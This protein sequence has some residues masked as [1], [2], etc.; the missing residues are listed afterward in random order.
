MRQHRQFYQTLD[1]TDAQSYWAGYL[2]PQA[3]PFALN[4]EQ[5]WLANAN[6]H[7]A[8][9]HNGW[10]MPGFYKHLRM[11]RAAD[12]LSQDRTFTAADMR[13]MQLDQR[14]ERALQWK[15]LLADTAERTGRNGLA[16]ELR[17]WDGMM[18]AESDLAGLFARWWQ[19]LPQHLFETSELEDWRFGRTLLDDWMSLPPQDIEIAAIEL[20]QAAERAFEDALKLGL[21]PLGSI[22]HLTIRHP[23]ASAGIL[24][25][26]LNLSRG[27]IPIG[28]GPGSL[29]VTYHRWNAEQARL[30]AAAGPSMRFVMDWANP[31]AFTLNTTM[32]QSGHPL[33]P[34]FD[35]FLQ[36]FLTGEPWT[37]PFSS[38]RVQNQSISTLWLV[39]ESP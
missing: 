39:P 15:G 2:E 33:S 34:H 27:P 7:A 38:E 3:R 14:S 30:S 31:D 19:F 24:N 6:N 29:N 9:E 21:R 16:E 5:H 20:E 18:A 11:R 22:Q 35:D 10:P 23:M 17:A 37:V 13:S 12:W 36:S 1:G 8:T 4:P 32:G 25:R 28:G 26:W